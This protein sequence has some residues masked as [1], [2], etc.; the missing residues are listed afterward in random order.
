MCK[1]CDEKSL[2]RQHLAGQHLSRR[3]LLRLGAGTAATAAVLASPMRNVFAEEGSDQVDL[4]VAN[5]TDPKG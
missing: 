4:S 2:S 3:G 5:V 1:Q